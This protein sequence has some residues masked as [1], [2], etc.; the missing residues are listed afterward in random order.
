[1][2]VEGALSRLRRLLSTVVLA[3]PYVSAGSVV[4]G[5]IEGPISNHCRHYSRAMSRAPKEK[6]MKSA[7]EFLSRVRLLASKCGAI[8]GK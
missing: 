4:S 5:A 3:C 2:I 1:M 7:E 8:T 6:A